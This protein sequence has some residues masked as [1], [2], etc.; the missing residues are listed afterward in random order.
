MGLRRHGGHAWQGIEV[1]LCASG[2][3][4][5]QRHPERLPLLRDVEVGGGE[6]TFG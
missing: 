6:T 3:S 1:Y 2:A 4:T 5:P